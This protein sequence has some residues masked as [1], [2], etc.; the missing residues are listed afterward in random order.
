MAK[1]KRISNWCHSGRYQKYDAVPPG[2]IEHAGRVFQ[3]GEYHTIDI[4]GSGAFGGPFYEVRERA[5]F[6]TRVHERYHG[7]GFRSRKAAEASIREMGGMDRAAEERAA[8]AERI[9]WIEDEELP[10]LERKAK[11]AKSRAGRATYESRQ[12]GKPVRKTDEH[13]ARQTDESARATKRYRQCKTDLR[14]AIK[15]QG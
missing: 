7:R 5:I 13:R 8:R 3:I 9:R 10:K 2:S 6:D 4:F 1:R 14:R 12:T 15:A 11:A